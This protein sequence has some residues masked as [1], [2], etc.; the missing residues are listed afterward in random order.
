MGCLNEEGWVVFRAL[1]PFLQT[2]CGN[3]W[4]AQTRHTPFFTHIYYKPSDTRLNIDEYR[5]IPKTYKC[6]NTYFPNTKIRK[7]KSMLIS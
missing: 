4:A 2:V 3:L 7:Q 1:G 6:I 5:R